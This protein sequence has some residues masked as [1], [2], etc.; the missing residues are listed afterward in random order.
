MAFLIPTLDVPRMSEQIWVRSSQ[1]SHTHEG[2]FVLSTVLRSLPMEHLSCSNKVA[3]FLLIPAQRPCEWNPGGSAASSWRFTALSWAAL[4]YGASSYKE[5][6]RPWTGLFHLFRCYW[7]LLHSLA[8]S[9]YY[10]FSHVAFHFIYEAEF[11]FQVPEIMDK[12]LSKY[13]GKWKKIA[14]KLLKIV[15]NPSK[16]DMRQQAMRWEITA[17]SLYNMNCI[18]SWMNILPIGLQ[19]LTTLMHWRTW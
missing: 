3:S 17:V 12:I 2:T 8:E 5:G 18:I 7:L 19:A 11:A 14:E 6:S 1:K 15:F 4:S 9:Y 13:E 10:A 16:I